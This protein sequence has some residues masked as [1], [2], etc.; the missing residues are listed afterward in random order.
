MTKVT[1]EQKKNY[2]EYIWTCA[3]IFGEGDNSYN[4]FKD[5]IK[6]YYSDIENISNSE[7]TDLTNEIKALVF[8]FPQ[9]QFMVNYEKIND[10]DYVTAQVDDLKS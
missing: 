9:D 8:T 6:V 3:C 2:L 10:N 7:F 4:T 5:S 1:Y